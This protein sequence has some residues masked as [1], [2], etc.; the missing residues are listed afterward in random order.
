[1]I[2]KATMCLETQLCLLDSKKRKLENT[3]GGTAGGSVAAMLPKDA[4]EKLDFFGLPHASFA[5]GSY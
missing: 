1:M 4:R 3:N 2:D 5:S